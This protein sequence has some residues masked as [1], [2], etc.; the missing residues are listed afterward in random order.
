L[1]ILILG[2]AEKLKIS[3]GKPWPEFK[4]FRQ[5]NAGPGAARN[6]RLAEAKGG[7]YSFF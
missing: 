5:E 4:V 1:E 2:E 7:V 3:E 6:R